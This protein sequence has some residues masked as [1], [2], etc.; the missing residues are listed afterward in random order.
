MAT[1]QRRR[2]QPGQ[3][4]DTIEIDPDFRDHIPPP[5]STELADLHRK[6]EAEG[7]REALLVWKGHNLLVDGHNRLAWFRQ[8]GRPFWVEEREFADREAVKAYIKL[9]RDS[10]AGEAR[11]GG[12]TESDRETEGGGEAAQGEQQGPGDADGPP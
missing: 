11:A 9:Q 5:T 2:C 4:S 12:A 3:P 6:L 10:E 8:A 1:K 7:C